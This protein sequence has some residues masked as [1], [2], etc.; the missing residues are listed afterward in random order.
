MLEATKPKQIERVVVCLT[1]FVI[2]RF[3]LYQV[4]HMQKMKKI[5]F[6]MVRKGGLVYII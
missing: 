5:V 6:R 4:T 3:R 2:N 1:Y